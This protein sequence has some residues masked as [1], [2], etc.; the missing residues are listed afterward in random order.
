MTE[1]QKLEVVRLYNLGIR[2][3]S[4]CQVVGASDG[5]VKRYLYKVLKL[6]NRNMKHST[7]VLAKIKRLRI[8]GKKGKEI[9]EATGMSR[10]QIRYIMNVAGTSYKEIDK[11]RG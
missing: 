7:G 11:S 4:I 9:Q 6:S 3:A 5:S 8:Y 1:E 10:N 2:V